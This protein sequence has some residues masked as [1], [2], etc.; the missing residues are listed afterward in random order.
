[1]SGMYSH[2][3]FKFGLAVYVSNTF[4]A[5]KTRNLIEVNLV[6]SLRHKWYRGKRIERERE[7]RMNEFN[8]LDWAGSFT[9]VIR[10]S[11]TVTL[12]SSAIFKAHL[13]LYKPIGCI[14]FFLRA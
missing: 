10:N 13:L 12:H 2:L 7:R 11:A 5:R 8:P 6:K 3:V 14:L 1:M 4:L 9:F